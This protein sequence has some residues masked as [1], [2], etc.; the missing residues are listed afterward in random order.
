MIISHANLAFLVWLA[1]I[2]L[3]HAAM[4]ASFHALEES[5][6]PEHTG[7][8]ESKPN[9]HRQSPTSALDIGA[10]DREHINPGAIGDLNDVADVYS[11]DKLAAINGGEQ[12]RFPP[13]DQSGLHTDRC[14][15]NHCHFARD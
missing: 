8:M 9:I 2:V 11:L 14:K 12:L 1:A 6:L 13:E 10:I 15:Y 4:E 7:K 3:S 5:L